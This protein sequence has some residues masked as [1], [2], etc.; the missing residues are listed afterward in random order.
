M[1]VSDTTTSSTTATPS[2]P[3]DSGAPRRRGRWID[4]WEP[5]DPAFWDGGGAKVA[6]RNLAWSILAE[7]VGFSVWMLW[8]VSTVYLA[9]A[10]FDFSVDQLFWLAAVPSLVGATMRFPYTFAV[11]RFGGRN[12]TTTS[13]LL[14]LVPCAL[15]LAC[16][17]NPGT[18]YW[19]FVLAAVSAG[20]GGG[21]FA[22]S[23]ANISYFYPD[24]KKGWA[25]GL[26][27]AGGNVGVSTVQLITPAVVG[28]GAAA[29]AV[30]LGNVALVW[31]PLA[32]VAALGA[33]LFMD[34]LSTA[35]SPMRA[36]LQVAKDR[37][38]WVMAFLYIG[39]FGSF[40]GYGAAMPLLMATQF[41]EVSG[42]YAFLGALVGSLVRPVGGLLADRWGGAR[43]TAATFVAMGLGVL[44]VV[45]SVGQHAFGPFLAA[46]M[47]LFT[48]AGIGNG[49]TYRMIPA[50]FRA[51]AGADDEARARSRGQ[52]AAALGVVSAVGAY[53]GFLIPRSFG[54]SIAHTGGIQAALLGFVAFYAACA[55]LTWWCY[56]RSRVLAARLPSLAHA[57]V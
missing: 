43:I 53:G 57:R 37:Q 12:W 45:W 26:N 39:T 55:V 27:A 47:V 33:W 7:H 1:T 11:A 18:P 30:R 35:R 17:S 14:L 15:L 24:A 31:A 8:S 36:Q 42:Q 9:Q 38:T 54:I 23:M 21:N 51:R 5:E 6:R 56:L 20:V 22:S 16:V 25:L 10:G 46:F 34:N 50:I 44:G 2:A 52:S 48:L 40:I 19:M 13:A 3:P 49:S 29:G 32:L 4:R 41:P 28:V